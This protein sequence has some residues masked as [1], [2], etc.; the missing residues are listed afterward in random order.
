MQPLAVCHTESLKPEWW[1]SPT[2]KNFLV[3]CVRLYLLQVSVCQQAFHPILDHHLMIILWWLRML[4]SVSISEMTTIPVD[5]FSPYLISLNN[6][7][8]VVYLAWTSHQY[9]DEKGKRWPPARSATLCGYQLRDKS[10]ECTFAWPFWWLRPGTI[11]T[12]AGE[13]DSKGCM[14]CP[15]LFVK[16]T[17]RF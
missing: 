1:T 16:M 2:A 10:S 8:P 5:A 14:L 11:W 13:Q 6:L 9:E 12:D 4:H 7:C 3:F 15:V 17:F